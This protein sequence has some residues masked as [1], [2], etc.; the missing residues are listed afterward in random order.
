MANQQE[1]LKQIAET[2]YNVGYGAKKHFA[3]AEFVDKLPGWASL[4]SIA[5][6][7]FGLIFPALSDKVP[8]AV[9]I[10]IGVATVYLGYYDKAAY[11][12]AGEQLTASFQALSS[13]YRD[14]KSMPANSDFSAKCSEYA[15]LRAEANGFGISRQ[16][17][18][19]DTVAHYKFFWQQ[20][21]GWIEEQ[22]TFTFWRDKVPL[23]TTIAFAILILAALSV[24]AW[25]LTKHTFC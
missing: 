5:I 22:I 15:R 2:G 3:T 4:I 10:V 19:S 1:L 7:V 14:V 20:Q 12:K 24:G 25:V 23:T 6:G 8:S 13:L 11:L 17:F 21:I 9:L 16:I 18:L